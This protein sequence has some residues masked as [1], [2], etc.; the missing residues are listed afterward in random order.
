MLQWHTASL[1][2][3]VKTQMFDFLNEMH[4][5]S[6]EM[7]NIELKIISDK[8]A[9]LSKLSKK[10]RTKS[11]DEDP[12]DNVN[13]TSTQYFYDFDGE[14]WADELGDYSFGLGSHCLKGG[15]QDA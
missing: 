9:H 8:R 1:N 2:H 13:R 3:Y 7:S 5:F 11:P 10:S 4:R 15:S 14:F 6:Y 12:L